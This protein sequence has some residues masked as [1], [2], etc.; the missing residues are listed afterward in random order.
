MGGISKVNK[1]LFIALVAV[2]A[3]ISVAVLRE[4]ND[5]ED[6]ALR[7]SQSCEMVSNILA[8]GYE[9]TNE[10][11][12]KGITDKDVLEAIDMKAPTCEKVDFVKKVSDTF[13]QG[14]AYLSNGT[15]V[16]VGIKLE[17]GMIKVSIG[18]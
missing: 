18:Q 10:M 9:K 16:S 2:V 13:Y 7:E 15:V 6:V 8:K 5:R 11:I 14:N 4:S 1:I 3:I 17:E 12:T